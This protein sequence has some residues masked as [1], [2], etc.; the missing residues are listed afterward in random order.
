ML[1]RVE[2]IYGNGRIE[3]TQLP[4]NVPEETKAIVTFIEPEK[5][6]LDLSAYGIDETHAESLQAKLASF[7]EDWNSLEMS[8]YDDYDAAKSNRQIYSIPQKGNNR[9][10]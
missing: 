7:A 1:T 2:G 4:S 3:L 9:G 10:C 5:E 6:G 8:L